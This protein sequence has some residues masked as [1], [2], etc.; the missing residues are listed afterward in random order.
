MNYRLERHR[1]PQP[2]S[3]LNAY[4]KVFTGGSKEDREQ[5]YT[6][7]YISSITAVKMY[8]SPLDPNLPI[9]NPVLS[10]PIL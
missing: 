1:K 8:F 5:S 4:R 7:P 10:H 3:I 6:F 9:P 2:W